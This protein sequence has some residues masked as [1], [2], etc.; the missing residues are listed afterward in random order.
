VRIFELPISYAGRTYQEGKKI[1]WR[2]GMSA[3]RC[4]L[5]YGLRK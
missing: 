4:I 5:K 2:D 3:F 1:T